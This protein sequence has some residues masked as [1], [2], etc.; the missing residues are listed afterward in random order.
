[1]PIGVQARG[2]RNEELL[3]SRICASG[4]EAV[5]SAKAERK[6][7]LAKGGRNN[8]VEVVSNR[9]VER[10]KVLLCAVLLSCSPTRAWA[11]S[12]ASAPPMNELARADIVFTGRVI[13]LTLVDDGENIIRVDLDVQERFKGNIGPRQSVYIKGIARPAFSASTVNRDGSV[14]T[15]AAGSVESCDYVAFMLGRDYLVFG[16]ANDSRRERLPLADNAMVTTAASA[17][18]ELTSDLPRRML[19]EF[20]GA[21]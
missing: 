8:R 7:H 21:R 13:A 10:F 19:A 4:D 9:I 14:T 3:Y 6:G 12:W 2:L 11:C 16:Y 5:A 15:I 1:M 20:R 17:T 18:G